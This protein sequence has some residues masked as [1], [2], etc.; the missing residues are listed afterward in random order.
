MSKLF[1]GRIQHIHYFLILNISFYYQTKEVLVLS[2]MANRS[3]NVYNQ[4]LKKSIKLC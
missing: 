1:T 4:Q 2:R 3:F